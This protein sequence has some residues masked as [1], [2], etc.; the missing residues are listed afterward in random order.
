MFV[1]SYK[2]HRRFCCWSGKELLFRYAGSSWVCVFVC[3]G[4]SDH[5]VDVHRVQVRAKIL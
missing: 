3:G 1:L 2:K 5:T 4:K